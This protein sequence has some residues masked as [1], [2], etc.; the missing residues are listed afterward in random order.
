M[1]QHSLPTPEEIQSSLVLS[2]KTRSAKTVK[3]VTWLIVIAALGFAQ[4]QY[5]IGQKALTYIGLQ[6]AAPD[7]TAPA[8]GGK[9]GGGGPI[10]VKLADAAN[11]DLPLIEHAY[12]T[13]QAMAQVNINARISSQITKVL[14]QDG[15][16]VKAGDELLVLD[17]RSLQATLA[18]DNA[19]LAKDN[20]ALENA[21]LQMLRA[22]TL[23][24]SNAGTQADYDT[25]LASEKIAEQ[26]IEADQAVIDADKLQLDFAI[27]KAPIDGKLGAVAAM[28]GALVST[29]GTQTPLMTIT[30]MQPLK[31]SFRLPEQ[32]LPAIR[33][34]MDQKNDVTVRVYAS[35]THDLL[36]T[37]KLTF[38]DSSVDS[39]SG[40]I[41]LAATM[42]NEKL[43]LWPGQHL[44]VEVQ[45]GTVMGA[46]AV[47]TVA[48]QQGQIGSF[49][50]TIDGDNKATATP[51]DVARYEGNTAAIA[52]GLIVGQKVVVEG[53]A[54]LS[55][56][57]LVRVGDA[58]KTVDAKPA[59]GTAAP[60]DGTAKK[61]R[62]KDA[63]AT[64]Q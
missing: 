43:V 2:A 1:N 21:K 46:L 56:G 3:F 20:A 5:Q 39:S 48:V 23:A 19:T 8:N 40:T 63:G 31:I 49:V 25:A 54:K 6:K 11:A 17:D 42:V 16:D 12:G 10:A 13:A 24:A 58:P 41:G 36:D 4:W 62:K 15:Q 32:V 35:G 37:G 51:V 50:W 60:A 45:Y 29:G 59:D 9:R 34:Q 22:K 47:P 52:K 7:L 64:Q 27:I 44:E 38:V 28:P 33:S 18:K 55:N 30:Q 26:V 14:V 53:Q 61:H 57:A